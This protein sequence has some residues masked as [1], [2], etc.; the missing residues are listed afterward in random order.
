MAQAAMT[1]MARHERRAGRKM[2]GSWVRRGLLAGA[3]ALALSSAPEPARAET[4]E[5][6]LATAYQSNPSL[7]AERAAV[8]VQDE[9]VAQALS[10][11]RPTVTLNGNVGEQ[12]QEVD[13][14]AFGL[15]THRSSEPTP[16][17]ASLTV[18]QN[19]YKGGGIA[20]QTRQSEF[21]VLVERS[22]LQLT[23]QTVLVNAATAYMDVLRDQAVLDLNVNNEQVLA[24]QLEATRDQFQAGTVTRTD[25]AQSEAALSQAKAGR[26]AA[27]NQLQISRANY[28]NVVGEL[29]GAL[30]DPHE[31]DGLPSSRDD[32]LSLAQRQNPNV[33]VADYVE[34]AA[35]AGV[36]VAFSGLLPTLQLQGVLSKQTEQSSVADDTGLGV[37]RALLTVPLYTG[38]LADSQT[39]QAKELVGQ[40]R[41]ELEQAQRQAVQD[42]TTAWESLQSARAQLA[43]FQD[44]VTA[45]NIAFEGVQ[46]EERAGL[47]TVLDVLN[48]QQALLQSQVNVVT[49]HHDAIVAAYQVLN[50]TGRL[51]AQDRRLPVE[52]YDPTRHYFEVRDKWLGTGA[53]GGPQPSASGGGKR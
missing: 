13:S 45:N 37:V 49:S 16:R 28:R 48:A 11:W 52:Y 47:R 53:A 21:L 26:E 40:R 9:G 44:Q 35:Q 46:Q 23:E 18:T 38:G 34:R 24:R 7:Q 29:P 43:S 5:E 39:R 3:A 30:V 6:A 19:I 15:S 32:V 20:A 8:R 31:P 50:T 17:G 22:R 27:Q 41:L 33:L 36:D 14:K 12:V 1:R 51:T 10:G 25:V 4:I 42:A 2:A